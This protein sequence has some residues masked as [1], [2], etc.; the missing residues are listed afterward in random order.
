MTRFR[1]KKCA[2]GAE[3]LCELVNV[4]MRETNNVKVDV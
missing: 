4:W 2:S 1:V 3:V